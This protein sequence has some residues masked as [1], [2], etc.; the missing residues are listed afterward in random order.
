MA[1]GG[2][3]QKKEGRRKR[4]GEERGTNERQ[5]GCKVYSTAYEEASG[6]GCKSWTARALSRVR[7]RLTCLHLARAECKG[8]R[9]KA[10]GRDSHVGQTLPFDQLNIYISII[11]AINAVD[12]SVRIQ[13]VVDSS[14]T[15]LFFSLAVFTLREVRYHF[16]STLQAF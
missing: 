8:R 1:T 6:L 14:L 13:R 9:R 12:T 7:A 4:R 15:D 2:K 10:E 5:E 11:H 3:R 16:S